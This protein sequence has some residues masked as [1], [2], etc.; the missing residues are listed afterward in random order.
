M[1]VNTREMNSIE[2]AFK[3]VFTEYGKKVVKEARSNLTREDHNN[4]KE[5]YDSLGY[6]FKASK[7]SFEFNFVAEYYGAFIDQGVKGRESSAKAP[8]S[9]FRFKSN[10]AN[11]GAIRKW[12]Q[13]KRFQFQSKNGRFMS[14]DSTAFLISRSIARDGIKA[15]NFLNR[16]A[17][18]NRKILEKGLDHG[19]ENLIDGIVQQSIQVQQ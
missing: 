19:V 8:N 4:S 17:E 3:G 15:T 7:N 5:L 12:V 14:Y 13:D 6:N 2:K 1:V 9:P 18:R 10:F 11:Y 16:P